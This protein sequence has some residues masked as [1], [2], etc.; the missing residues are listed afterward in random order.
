MAPPGA[1]LLGVP[2]SRNALE[3]FLPFFVTQTIGQTNPLVHAS[4]TLYVTLVPFQ[5]MAAGSNVTATGLTGTQTPDNSSLDV[6]SSNFRATGEWTQ[7]A[8]TMV[9]FVEAQLDKDAT[10]TLSFEVQNSGAAQAA[11]VATISGCVQ[12]AI[13]GQDFC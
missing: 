8:G 3:I 13:L 5:D 6:V 10:Y 12:A 11:V 1:S 4:N 7:D 9:V 2:L